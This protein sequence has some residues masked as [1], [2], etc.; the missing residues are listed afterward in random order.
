MNSVESTDLL[1]QKSTIINREQSQGKSCTVSQILNNEC[2]EGQ[3]NVNQLEEIKTNFNSLKQLISDQ[4]IEKADDI[5]KKGK[6]IYTLF[7]T[8]LMIFCAA[9]VVFMLLLCL[10][11][12]ELCTN[13]TCCQYFCKFFLHF[14]WNLM[15]YYQ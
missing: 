12:G 2:L 3:I 11:S 10:C 9:I 7:F 4:I 14:L 5:D 6:L 13:L 15:I 8:F 1:L